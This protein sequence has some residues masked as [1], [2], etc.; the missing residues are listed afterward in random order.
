M[1]AY[2]GDAATGTEPRT[3]DGKT[4][5][6]VAGTDAYKSE[7]RQ[8]MRIEWDVP[9]EM[10]DGIVLR[11]DVFRPVEDGAY[12]AIMSYGPYGKLLHF[13]EGYAAQWSWITD[14]RPDVIEGSSNK[15]QNFEV[16]DPEKFVPIGYAVVRFDS[17][18]AGRSPGYL[19]P[20]SAREAKDL[21]DCIEWT[22]RQPWCNGK[23]GLSGTSYLAM[24]Q[25][26]V[27][28]LQPPHLA[29]LCVWEGAAD[30]YRDMTRHGGILCTFGKV[31]YGPVVLPVQHGLGKRGYRGSMN[32]EWVSGPETLLDEELAANR[33]DW[34]AE[35]ARHRLA[36][37]EFWRSRLPDFSK[38][39]VPL[40]STANWGGQGLHLRGN[41]EGFVGAATSD[42]WLDIH[43]L[44]HW[45]EYYTAYGVDLQKRFFGHFLKG[46][47]SGWS[48]QPR[49]HMLV[50]HPGE[51]YVWRD[52]HE[53]PLARTRWTKFY[54]DP[55][56]LSLRVTPSRKSGTVTY[57]GFSDGVT[58]VTPPLQ[59]EIEIT[60]PIAAKLFVSSATEDADIFVV[61]R[62]LAP[63]L[64][65][66]TF[67]GH[68]D[69]HTPIAQGWL[70][71]SHRKLD[72]DR[73]LPYR[74]YHAHDEIQKLSPGQIHELDVEVLPTCV[75]VP[76]GF[77]IA[78]SVRG[79][80]YVY[81]GAP[82]AT[83]KNPAAF[84]GVGLFR[85]N[86]GSDRPPAVFDA[87]V[88]LHFGPGAKAFVLL[89]VIPPK[90]GP[91]LY[92]AR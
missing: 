8:G 11:C 78:F 91:K 39:N 20:W 72:R 84:T 77:R 24:N 1:G 70:R 74:P 71:A 65:E 81:P 60:G 3:G 88:S 21:H 27:A 45:T 4:H 85:H 16:V 76:K 23:V 31:W 22:A 6:G 12:P 46:E 43:C 66:V 15:F 17:R 92:N 49:I 5:S 80:D 19:D 9:V 82:T 50:R 26:Q 30:Y 18:G 90:D 35:C 34:H 54:L 89:P 13:A 53:W 55:A 62:V 75:V 52:E 33:T 28:S 42:K 68:I 58:F 83:I 59:E 10:D 87:D 56:D 67:P 41:I 40:L 14:G 2:R 57:R 73:S 44:D 37:D 32:G 63:D 38:I 36:T 51:R 25:W 48:H 29:A 64:R 79:K 69:P 86:D 47:E 61:L 7:V